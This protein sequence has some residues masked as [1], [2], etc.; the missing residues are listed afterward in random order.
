[1]Q[2]IR[3]MPLSCVFPPGRYFI[4]D[5]FHVLNMQTHGELCDG[6]YRNTKGHRLAMCRVK[7]GNGIYYSNEG[8]AFHVIRQN[9]SVVPWALCERME[10]SGRIPHELLRGVFIASVDPLSI[11]ASD[12]TLEIRCGENRTIRIGIGGIYACMSR[13][14]LVQE[15]QNLRE[16]LR[17]IDRESKED[18]MDS[19]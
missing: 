4:G 8:D 1:M 11:D 17:K 15:C 10:H 2:S 6:I 9:I 12:D 7:C 14:E 13:D 16:Q 19:M 18:Q 5:A 3:A